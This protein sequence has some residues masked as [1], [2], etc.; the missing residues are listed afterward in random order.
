MSNIEKYEKIIK[1]NENNMVE[2]WILYTM[3]L[4]DNYKR[5]SEDEK[6]KLLY[7]IYHLW[8]QT[9]GVSI[10]KISDII[11]ENYEKALNEEITRHDIYEYI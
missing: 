3:K 1:E 9:S 4:N 6:P 7:L 11:M 10:E 8:L 5:L 2:L